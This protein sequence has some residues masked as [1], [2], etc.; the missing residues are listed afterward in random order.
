MG[1]KT[2]VIPKA[3]VGRILMKN[4]AKRVSQDAMEAFSEV[5]IEVAEKIAAKAI[6]MSKHTGRKT[7]TDDDIKLAARH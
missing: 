4:G 1:R 3:P 7:V 6:E 2:T 5:L